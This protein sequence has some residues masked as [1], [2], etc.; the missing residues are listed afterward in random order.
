MK[1]FLSSL[2]QKKITLELE[3]T[4]WSL[5]SSVI[6]LLFVDPIQF[7]GNFEGCRMLKMYFIP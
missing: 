4:G 7:T 3:A 6:I 5:Q 1:R 2:I